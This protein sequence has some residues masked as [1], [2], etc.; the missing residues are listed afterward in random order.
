MV[1]VREGVET[2]DRRLEATRRE[3]ETR[4]VGEGEGE[5][6]FGRGG[7]DIVKRGTQGL[8]KDDVRKKGEYFVVGLRIEKKS[9]YLQI[10][11]K[12]KKLLSQ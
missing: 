3:R 8:R 6:L 5:G 2:K 12:Q 9:V 1:K 4:E 10:E 11:N 7:R